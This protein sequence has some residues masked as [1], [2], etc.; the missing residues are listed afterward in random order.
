[1]INRQLRTMYKSQRT[2]LTAHNE[3][4]FK[5]LTFK[6]H[7]PLYLTSIVPPGTDRTWKMTADYHKLTEVVALLLPPHQFWYLC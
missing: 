5:V 2:F 1:M 6:D 7:F 3:A 4:N